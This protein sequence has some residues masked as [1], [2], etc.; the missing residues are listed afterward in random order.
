MGGAPAYAS[1]SVR[2]A[3]LNL[4]NGAPG[5]FVG[6]GSLSVSGGVFSGNT[7]AIS[8]TFYTKL[9]VAGATFTGNTGRYGGAISA[10]YDATLT[11]STF[12]G[13]SAQLGGAVYVQYGKQAITRCRFAGNTARY[14]GGGLYDDG[15][16]TMTGTTFTS[17]H[18]S[19]G[20]AVTSLIPSPPRWP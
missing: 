12:T 11:D 3:S 8:T 10:G 13:N 9:S 16:V 6:S 20:G 5:V 4:S 7:T 17:N 14:G 15:D 1:K 19:V 18:A 2:I